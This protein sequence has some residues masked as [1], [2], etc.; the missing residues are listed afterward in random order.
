MSCGDLCWM[1]TTTPLALTGCGSPWTVPWSR[2]PSEETTPGQIRQTGEKKGT[3]RSL[4]GDANGIPLALAVAGANVNDMV[5][6]PE[7]LD[8]IVAFRPIPTPEHEQNL[9]MDKGYDFAQ[10]ACQVRQHGFT[11]HIRHRGEG[12]LTYQDPGKP[13]RRWVIERSNSWMNRFRRILIRWEKKAENYV[14]MIEFA[15]SIIIFNKLKKENS[16]FG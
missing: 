8:N 14:A 11:P 5:L 10:T 6:V 2:L 9:A 16:L 12:K 3:K 1:S 7:T 4:L 13:A 15:F